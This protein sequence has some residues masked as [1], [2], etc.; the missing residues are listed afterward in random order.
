MFQSYKVNVCL[1]PSVDI[2]EFV[3][4]KKAIFFIV[5]LREISSSLYEE[6]KKANIFWEKMLTGSRN[7]C[8]SINVNQNIIFFWFIYSNRQITNWKK[9]NPTSALL[10][11]F[12]QERL[13]WFVGIFGRVTHCQNQKRQ[14]VPGRKMKGAGSGTEESHDLFIERKRRSIGFY[15]SLRKRAVSSTERAA[16]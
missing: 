6:L 7:W 10:R 14:F 5:D 16:Q 1:Q 12:N 8:V 11:L 13:R 15:P 2:K 4:L 9:K 3:Q